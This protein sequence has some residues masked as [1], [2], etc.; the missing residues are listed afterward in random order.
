M[1]YKI[2]KRL[3]HKLKYFLYY[4]HYSVLRIEI[5]MIYKVKLA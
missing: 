4:L 1:F 5:E 3:I 2:F